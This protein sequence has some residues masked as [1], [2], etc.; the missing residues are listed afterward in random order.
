MPESV[1]ETT[2]RDAIREYGR[3]CYRRGLHEGLSVAERVRDWLTR[4]PDTRRQR[5]VREWADKAIAKARR[6]DG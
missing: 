6:G 3:D 5:E 2:L 4:E 1:A